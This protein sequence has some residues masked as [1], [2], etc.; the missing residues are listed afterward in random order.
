[1]LNKYDFKYMNIKNKN[2]TD[3]NTEINF[4]CRDREREREISTR[5]LKN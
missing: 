1:M 3:M 2:Q 5:A 4:D